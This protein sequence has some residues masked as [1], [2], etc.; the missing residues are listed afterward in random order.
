[1][2]THRFA[3]GLSSVFALLVIHG[4]AVAQSEQAKPNIIVILA[5]DLGSGDIAALNTQSKI[6][7]PNLDRLVSEGMSFT[8]AHSPS[9]V[10]TP[11]RYGLLTGQYAWRT[12]LKRWVLG[13]ASASI[14]D[15][16]MP[17][18][19]SILKDNGYATAA[20]GKWHL[21]L[22]REDPTDFSKR[23]ETGPH[24]AGFEHFIGIPASL[25]MAPYV[26]VIDDEL[27]EQPT[28]KVKGSG[29]RR[30][31]GGGFYRAGAAAPS[32]DFNDV[33][34]RIGREACTM[35]DS[36]TK[37]ERP[38]FLYVALSAPHTPWMPDE[39]HTG[40]SSAGYYGDFV[41]MVDSVV[42]QVLDCLN[43]SG[44]AKNTLLVFT[45]DNG[46]H[47]PKEDVVTY[48]HAA[49]DHWR[50]QK[51]DIHEGG[52]R[53]PFIV[54]WPGHVQPATTS[55]SL[56]CLTDVFPTAVAAAGLAL[57]DGAAPDG[58][59]HLAVLRNSSTTRSPRQSIVHHSGDGMFAL[60]EGKWK[61]IE[62][63]G[64]GGFTSPKRKKATAGEP[65]MQ[66]YDLENDPAETTNLASAHPEVVEHLQ[67]L[68]ETIRQ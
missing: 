36:G 58:V 43:A 38:Y 28:A 68:L 52:H 49:N 40:K 23:F 47:W 10:C 11:T 1:M 26:W 14:I 50:G 27:E 9:A 42:G 44:E 66:L 53:V 56:L 37:D 20:T 4:V 6:P 12:A 15:P 57:P 67:S 25:D 17:T 59:S 34:P 46:A 51:A 16:A 32:F 35:I 29:H 19:P 60:R 63:R 13:G 41:A 39:Q 65:T 45:S 24:T 21:G 62:G 7:T 5:D 33:L 55:A 2:M 61:L 3:L 30:K 22:G 31:G 64:S 48:G 18:F 54:R 8:D